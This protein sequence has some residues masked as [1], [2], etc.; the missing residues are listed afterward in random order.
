MPN[1]RGRQGNLAAPRGALAPN[2]ARRESATPPVG[3]EIRSQTEPGDHFAGGMSRSDERIA[4][5]ESP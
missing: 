1:P 3:R 2:R 5:T 4:A